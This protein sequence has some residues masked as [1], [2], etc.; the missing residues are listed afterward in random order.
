MRANQMKNVRILIYGAGA[1]G[2]IFGGKLAF[3]GVDITML[4]RGKRFEELKKNDIIL[5]NVIN[6]KVERIKVQI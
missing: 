1:I 4:A 3:S 5:K 2:S 6:G